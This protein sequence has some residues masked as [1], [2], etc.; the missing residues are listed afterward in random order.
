MYSCI[1]YV[2]QRPH[3]V[4]GHLKANQDP[5]W[6]IPADIMWQAASSEFPGEQ[7]STCVCKNDWSNR[8]RYKELG[9]HMYCTISW[10]LQLSED[11]LLLWDSW[12]QVVC[13]PHFLL[14]RRPKTSHSCLSGALCFSAL[15]P[16]SSA[17]SFVPPESALHGVLMIRIILHCGH[18]PC[19]CMDH[20][21]IKWLL[22]YATCHMLKRRLKWFYK[23]EIA[24]NPDFGI[25]AA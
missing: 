17:S 7:S 9:S 3:A 2:G 20:N 14:A 11:R 22:V 21:L 13:G 1:R 6:V 24:D 5:F 10:L 8:H 18:E 25:R 15:L 4:P 12:A 19:C 23:L 16:F